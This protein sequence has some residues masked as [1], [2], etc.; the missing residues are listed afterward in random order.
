[1]HQL[2]QL[3][4]E[5]IA[6]GLR[7]KSITSC[8]KW[9]ERYRVMGPPFP[10]PWTF[11]Y[12]PWLK[13]MHDSVAEISVGQKAAQV[14]YT[15]WALNTTLF[16]LDIRAVDCLYVLPAQTPDAHDFSAA[17]FDP[18]LEMS[19][20]LKKMFVDVQN[21]GHKKLGNANLYIRGSR[22][23]SGLK[24]V[25][26]GL[27]ILDEVDEMT[28]ENIPLATQRAAGQVSFQIIMLST[29][30]IP[31]VGIN[32]FY[33]E[34]DQEHFFFKCPSC[35]RM[36]EL[37]YPECLEI[38][39]DDETDQ[40]VKDSYFKCKECK[41]KLNHETKSIWLA[42]NQWVPSYTDRDIRGFHVNQMYSSA[43]A[44]HPAEFAKSTFRAQKDPAE[45]QELFNSKLGVPHTIAGAA[46]TDENIEECRQ[47]SPFKNGTVRP[48]NIITMGIDVGKYIHFVI[49]D[50]FLPRI[51]TSTDLNI[52]ATPKTL[53]FGKVKEFEE[54]DR[55]LIEWNVHS[56]VID[57]NPERR[58]SYEFACRFWGHVKLC[59]YSRGISGKQIHNNKDKTGDVLDEHTVSVDRTS[60][61]DLSLGRFKRKA[62]MIPVDVDTEFKDH[63]K[64]LVRIY[65]KDRD[66]NSIGRYVNG[67]EADHYAHARNY[68]EI[69]LPFALNWNTSIDIEGSVV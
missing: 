47:I 3:I 48:S 63:M 51:R 58:K 43:K 12:H 49:E 37:V 21:V 38:I 6:S 10:G 40:R 39:G 2:E 32:K 8:S 61:L 17:R 13:E 25:P 15:E 56:A 29:P 59:I 28:Q 62:I 34:S 33:R 5:R 66:G 64:A 18:A 4:A 57:A 36:T 46:I 52:N 20:H 45:E 50:W 69:A 30:T 26:V 68:S 23:R 1:M 19:E 24:S 31:K 41:N 42:N 53:L 9:A 22:A 27:I 55:F 60:W 7:R 35:S 44:G 16:T 67:N 65:E 54:L 14:G 11:K